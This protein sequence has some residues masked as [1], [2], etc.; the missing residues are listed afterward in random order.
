MKT[1]NKKTVTLIPGDGIGPEVIDAARRVIEAAGVS[2]TWEVCEAGSEAFKKGLTSGVPRETLDSI[3]RNRVALKGPLETPI[4]YGEKSANVMLRKLFDTY[5]NIRPIRSFP[6]VPTP[7]L[8]RAIDFIIVRENVEDLYAGMEYRAG[9]DVAHA[10]KIMSREGCARIVRLAFELARSQG[11][12]TVHC[13]TKANILKLTE[14]LLKQVFEEI[15]PEYPDLQASHLLVDN[16]AHQMVRFPEKFDVVVMSNM[17]GDILSDM[18]SGLIGGLGFAPGANLGTKVAIFE[19]VHGSAP[20]YAGQD[21]IN[22]TAVILSGVMM[23]RHLGEFE[24]ADRIENA[25]RA[26]LHQGIHTQDV[27]GDAKPVG[28]RAFTEAIVRYMEESQPGT[29]ELLKRRYHALDTQAFGDHLSSSP[30]SWRRGGVDVFL[31]SHETPDRLGASCERVVEG[32][33]FRFIFL[34]NRGF[35]VYPF[36]GLQVGC[37]SHWR[38]RFLAQDESL[39]LSENAIFDLLERLSTVA[40]WGSIESLFFEGDQP[41]FTKAQG[42]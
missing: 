6:G 38:A 30:K 20:R 33:P 42:E 3:V 15:A 24:A 39:S 12:Q 28:T 7:F 29:G 32:T 36:S 4:G 14:G 17:N 22:P 10:L 9:P 1:H 26:I 27:A 16:C 34:D 40:S 5:G 11:R 19:A 37:T 23:L 8:D 25:L 31:E 18:A 21:T 41:A 35:V 13:A 2:L